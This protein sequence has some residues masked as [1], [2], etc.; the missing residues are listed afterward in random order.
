M[1]IRDM[2]RNAI[3]YGLIAAGAVGFS[4]AALAGSD[5]E[6][7]MHDD[8]SMSHDGMKSEQGHDGVSDELST[9]NDDLDTDTGE[10]NADGI[11]PE[12]DLDDGMNDSM[13]NQSGMSDDMDSET[14]ELGEDINEHNDTRNNSVTD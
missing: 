14:E 1:Y 5:K 13:D 7:G 4:G 6:N 12:S 8:K 2:T 9:P 3:A 10:S 11:A